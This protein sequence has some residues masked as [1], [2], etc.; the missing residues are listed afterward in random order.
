MTTGAG[1]VLP[2]A[3]DERAALIAARAGF[4]SGVAGAL[5]NTLLVAYA[6]LAFV[7][8][9][10]VQA[11]LWPLACAT[12]GASAVL[13]VPLVL[14]LGGGSL[15]SLGVAST[16]FSAVAFL[17]LLTGML[18]PTAGASLLAGCGI[19]FAA[20]L[21]LVCRGETVP[22]RAARVGRR[23][24]VAALVGTAVVAAGN[25]AL[26]VASTAWLLVLVLGGVP[27]VLG[28]LAVPAWT[29]RVARWVRQD[30]AG[31]ARVHDVPAA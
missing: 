29:L 11:A 1:Q 14:V 28:W 24:G 31:G 17:M 16:A 22:R 9:G 19:G 30:S 7:R 4:G 10:P 27:A 18:A 13:L 15:V 23:V 8:P 12:A 21:F 26:P 2:R 20:W 3:T 6:A 25:V 5:A